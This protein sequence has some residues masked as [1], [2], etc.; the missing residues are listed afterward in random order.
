MIRRRFPRR[1][2][3]VQ[4][5][6]LHLKRQAA[7]RFNIVLTKEGRRDLVNQITSGKARCIKTE[8]RRV[9]HYIVRLGDKQAVQAICVYDR[10]RKEPVTLLPME[11]RDKPRPRD[12]MDE[13][14]ELAS[15][16]N[17]PWPSQGIESFPEGDDE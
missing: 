6:R 12:V 8:S 3:K 13:M 7:E 2:P 11:W 4:M 9:A 10:M 5:M 15:G 14:N 16:N 17:V 1:P